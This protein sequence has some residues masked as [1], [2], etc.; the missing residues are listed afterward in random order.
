MNYSPKQKGEDE[1]MENKPAHICFACNNWQTD[2]CRDCSNY[3]KYEE[4]KVTK[5]IRLYKTTDM[6]CSDDYKDRFIAE[7]Q[8]LK[9][10]Y[11]K[12]RLFNVKIRA[13]EYMN[14]KEL[15][16]EVNCPTALLL[17]QERAMKSYMDILE[18]RIVIEGIDLEQAMEEFYE[19]D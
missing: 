13:A 18:K 3:E 6:M 7:Y 17:D 12:L 15:M 8:Q 11:E 9:Y 14:S 1:T 19:A 10:R 16:P 2:E 5:K 4:M